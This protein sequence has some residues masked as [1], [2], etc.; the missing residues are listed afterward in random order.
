[1]FDGVVDDDAHLLQPTVRAEWR[2]AHTKDPTRVELIIREKLEQYKRLEQA[3]ITSTKY[4]GPHT[5]KFAYA[6]FGEIEIDRS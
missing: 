3:V 5:F 1:V 4:E 6:L 2:G